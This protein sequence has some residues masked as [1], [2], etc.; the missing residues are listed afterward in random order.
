MGKAKKVEVTLP[1]SSKTVSKSTSSSKISKACNLKD[2][3]IFG[4]KKFIQDR[5][6]D[7]N[8]CV[9]S[10]VH[11]I[12]MD[13]N[14]DTWLNMIGV[15]NETLVREFYHEFEASTT[16]EN[17]I[18]DVRGV[19]FRVNSRKLNDFLGLPDDIELDFLD[20]DVVENLDLMGKTL[21]DDVNFMWGKRSFIR[22]SELT[23]VS[24]FWH[25]FVCSNLV[26]SSNA[27]E[28]NK[29]KIKIVYALVTNKPI[30]LG[31]VLIEHI[32][33][34]ASSSR[35]EKKLAFP[36]F[37]SHLCLAKGVKQEG[38]DVLIPPIEKLSEKRVTTMSYKGKGG[39][40]D[41]FRLFGGSLNTSD[42]SSASSIPSWAILLRKEVEESRR[43]IEASQRK[44]EELNAK[45]M[46]QDEKIKLL[47]RNASTS[48][49]YVRSSN[50]TIFLGEKSG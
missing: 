47:E 6:I 41:T 12:I 46:Q 11:K 14:W 15:I 16:I 33:I 26:V 22:Q 32:E 24:A 42:V 27:T 28:L 20:V 36:G 49:Q 39:V 18:M 19:V 40:S 35:L 48:K 43:M 29:E 4:R 13:R 17:A 38:D 8:A 9:G 23:K 7:L 10:Y 45:V 50:H 44:I 25:M 5:G 1:S 30:N 37:I 31:E 34:A 2:L 21:C 3:E